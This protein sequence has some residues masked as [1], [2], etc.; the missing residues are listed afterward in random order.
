MEAVLPWALNWVSW[1]TEIISSRGGRSGNFSSKTDSTFSCCSVILSASKD[2]HFKRMLPETLKDKK[3]MSPV[4]IKEVLKQEVLLYCFLS[5]FLHGG[6][7]HWEFTEFTWKHPPNMK[8]LNQNWLLLQC[9]CCSH[10][11]DPRAATVC[12]MLWYT[13]TAVQHSQ[14]QP[15]AH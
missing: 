13:N 4:N 6:C 1:R 11:S 15:M 8:L 12:S 9:F 2:M 5:P 3:S 10:L 7:F 14:Q